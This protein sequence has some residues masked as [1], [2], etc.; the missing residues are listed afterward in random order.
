MTEA[1]EKR[2]RFSHEMLIVASPTRCATARP[3]NQPAESALELQEMQDN[4]PGH[5]HNSHT[6]FHTQHYVFCALCGSYGK[7]IRRT[8]LHLGCPRA[9]CN[10]WAGIAIQRLMDGIEPYNVRTRC[11]AVPYTQLTWPSSFSL[12]IKLKC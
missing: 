11:S 10:R 12:N 8:T 5:L 1:V 7:Q 4:L 9:P 2:V 3:P 6:L